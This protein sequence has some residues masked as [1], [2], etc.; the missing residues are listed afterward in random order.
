LIQQAQVYEG[1]G[2]RAYRVIRP[3]T[4]KVA[5]D[6][7]EGERNFIGFL[8]FYH[9][10]SRYD[11][12]SYYLLSKS[13]NNISK[14]KHCVQDNPEDGSKLIMASKLLSYMGATAR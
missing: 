7:S 9:L 1:S 8:R 5:K 4:G 14:I 6:L 11:V 13:N 2:Q 10:V 3:H 12:A